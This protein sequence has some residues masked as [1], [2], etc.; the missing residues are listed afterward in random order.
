MKAFFIVGVQRSGTTLL[1]SLLD[2]H[3]EVYMEPR[4]LGFRMITCFKNLYELLPFNAEVDKNEL[5]A[6]LVR[7]DDK[8]RL[9][10]LIDH[11]N[12]QDYT[13]VRELISGSI[14]KQLINKGKQVWGDK[15]PNLQHYLNDLML[16]M[17]EAKILHIVRDGRAN[18]YSMS[19]RSYRHL[20]LSAQQWM[21]GNV[22]GLVNRQILGAENYHLIRYEE[23]LKQ[24]ELVAKNICSFLDIPYSVDMLNLA[25]EQYEK[26]ASYVKNYF[27]QSKIDKWKQ[28]LSRKQIQTIENIQG[29]LLQRLGYQLE[30]PL[31]DL[32][33]KPLSLRRQIWYNQKDNIRQ[34]FQAKRAGMKNKELIEFQR[35]FKTRAYLFLRTLARDLV[36]LPIFKSLFS[37]LYFSKKEFEL[38]KIKKEILP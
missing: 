16:L 10:A 33:F 23:L 30:T 1:S 20:A 14:D 38:D 34:L 15:A 35:P 31:A 2:Q 6:W 11:E 32:K 9:A 21:N 27:D 18:A 5:L 36:A 24:P 29:P 37:H 17:P 8:G 26:E 22:F 25:G 3:P 28:Q 12:I 4:V 7:Q 13:T 19:T